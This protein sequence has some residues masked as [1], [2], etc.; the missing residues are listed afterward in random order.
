MNFFAD[1]SSLKL[2]QFKSKMEELIIKYFQQYEVNLNLILN[3]YFFNQLYF[4]NLLQRF[5]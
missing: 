2:V 1:L 5:I 3:H 4:S